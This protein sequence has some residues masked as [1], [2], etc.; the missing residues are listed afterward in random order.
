MRLSFV[1]FAGLLQLLSPSQVAIK[2]PVVQ[3]I[4]VEAMG[5][6][7]LYPLAQALLDGIG[8]RLTG[9]PEQKRANAWAI[10]VYRS[11]GIT[12]RAEQYGTW[13]GWRR[14]TMHADLLAPRARSLEGTLMT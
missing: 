9:S 5:K 12:A 1:A 13:N 8:P 6:S 10:A 14:G 11:W 7:Q 2:D 3:K 4:W